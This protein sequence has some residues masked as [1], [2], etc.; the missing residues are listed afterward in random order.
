MRLLHPAFQVRRGFYRQGHHSSL[1]KVHNRPK[2][3]IFSP[4]NATP[5]S[6]ATP[7]STPVASKV[8]PSHPPP[9]LDGQSLPNEPPKFARMRRTTTGSEFPP[10]T[11]SANQPSPNS[12]H[13]AS[14]SKPIAPSS[15]PSRQSSHSSI[16]YPSDKATACSSSSKRPPRPRSF[17][18]SSFTH[19]TTWGIVESP[20]PSILNARNWKQLASSNEST[21]SASSVASTSRVP[22]D[23]ASSWRSTDTTTDRPSSSTS[24]TST[25]S[26]SETPQPRKQ[27]FSAFPAELFPNCV[28]QLSALLPV[29][30]E[31]SPGTSRM[32]SNGSG[33]SISPQATQFE[34]NDTFNYTPKHDIHGPCWKYQP[35]FLRER[36]SK[37]LRSRPHIYQDRVSTWTH[38]L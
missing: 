10:A 31:P 28:T 6:S 1:S 20:K 16:D 27:G 33:I 21:S 5:R 17:H 15:S 11:L 35:S 19:T 38:G 32:P 12:P 9:K 36:S 2:S 8:E 25:G 3:T 26:Y 14:D 7:K 24:A 37:K 13:N 30:L 22:L 34:A 29:S 4:Q 23:S 18:G